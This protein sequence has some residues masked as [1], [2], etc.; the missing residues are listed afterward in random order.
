MSPSYKKSNVLSV[1]F[2][3]NNIICTLTDITGKLITWTT[4]GSFKFRGVKKVT[5]STISSTIKKLYNYNKN[6]GYNCTHVKLKGINKHKILFIKNLKTIGFNISSL[7]DS[8]ILPH[9]G[10]RTNRSRRI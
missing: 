2:T 10:C 1:L 7:Q 4:T 6:F 9:N 5:A 3:K 8:L